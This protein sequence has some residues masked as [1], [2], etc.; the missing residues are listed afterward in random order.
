MRAMIGRRLTLGPLDYSVPVVA[1][2]GPPEQC[3]ISSGES[4]R[5]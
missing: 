5:S 1:L 4:S 2:H 3:V